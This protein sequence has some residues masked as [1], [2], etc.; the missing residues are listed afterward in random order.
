MGFYR[1]GLY[2]GRGRK[3][4]LAVTASVHFDFRIEVEHTR[5]MGRMGANLV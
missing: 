5:V 4:F 2:G 3:E 1:K